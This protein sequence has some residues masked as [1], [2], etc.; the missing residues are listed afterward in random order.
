MRVYLCLAALIFAVACD[1]EKKN[2]PP[3]TTSQPDA[4]AADATSPP[5]VDAGHA[6]PHD[7]GFGDPTKGSVSGR[8]VDI[9]GDALAEAEVWIGAR[10]AT[11][12]QVGRFSI[13]GLEPGIAIVRGT[14]DG[15][16]TGLARAEV[17]ASATAEVTLVNTRTKV[18]RHR[19]PGSGGMWMGEDRIEAV[20]SAAAIADQGGVP[21]TDQDTA[22]VNYAVIAKVK[23]MAATA[24]GSV[25]I[26][27]TGDTFAVEAFGA[28]QLFVLGSNNDL[29]RWVGTATVSIPSAR[30]LGPQNRDPVPLYKLDE[31]IGYWREVGTAVPSGLTI[32]ALVDSDGWWMTG[33]P[34]AEI[35]CLKGRLVY[36]GNQ[37]LAD[38]PIVARGGTY[39][40]N[41]PTRSDATGQYCV[42]VKLD[43]ASVLN[44]YNVGPAVDGAWEATERSGMTAGACGM[45]A[46]CVDMGDQTVPTTAR[47]C[48]SGRWG[49]GVDDAQT[50]WAV[51]DSGGLV[52]E[53][54]RVEKSPTDADGF[55]FGSGYGAT[56]EFSNRGIIDCMN[57]VEPIMLTPT[58]GNCGAPTSCIDVGVICR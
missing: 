48:L 10:Q 6:T 19:T 45:P 21:L 34:V 27:A 58:S 28:V 2:D 35:G 15:Y 29:L 9:D 20:F 8:M 43:A 25:A 24:G 13:G 32:D 51:K 47:M 55:C 46:N 3:P 5:R 56:V 7:A 41:F 1:E 57:T 37:P 31:S 53:Q 38:A 23:D 36:S 12:D 4:G 44:V 16:S 50:G 11:T 26:D 22:R 33:R 42:E 40:G 54:G 14:A 49:P 39:M 17:V 52:V 18:A 30:G